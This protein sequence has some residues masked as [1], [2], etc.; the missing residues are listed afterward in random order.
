[1]GQAVTQDPGFTDKARD[2]FDKRYAFASQG[3][4]FPHQPIYGFSRFDEHVQ[5]YRR[6]YQIL[7]ALERLSFSTFLDVGCAEGYFPNLARRLFGAASYGTD[8]AFSGVKRAR[9]IYAVPGAVGDAHKLP[10]KDRAF[11]VVLCSETLE[12]VAD[13]ERVI[14][15]LK[16]ICNKYLVITTPAAR[17]EEERETHFAQ[18]DPGVIFDHFHYFTEEEMRRWLGEA[19]LFEG[20]GYR[21]LDRWYAGISDGDAGAGRVSDLCGFVLDTCPDMAPETRQRYEAHL[22][23]VLASRRGRLARALAPLVMRLLLRADQWLSRVYP[24]ETHAFL[25][26]T[27]CNG[28]PLALSGRRI[29]NLMRFLLFENRVEPLRTPDR[30]ERERCSPRDPLY[31]HGAPSRLGARGS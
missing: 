28:A 17:T 2:W 21:A 12:H 15:E 8:F 19:T 20:C 11:D 23:Q 30:D 26:I 5:N 24:Q 6:T 27:P 10:F 9:D 18:V 4:Y 3:V 7:R 13:P 1:M 31:E 29:P 16:R 22:K 14:G 25:T